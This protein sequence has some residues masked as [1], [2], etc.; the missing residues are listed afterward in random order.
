MI[1][2]CT[3]QGKKDHNITD[4]WFI[5]YREGRQQEES[6][7]DLSFF[8]PDNLDTYHVAAIGSFLGTDL[9]I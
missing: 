3:N 1:C 7:F 9:M 4:S 2:N 8:T 5:Y 6:M